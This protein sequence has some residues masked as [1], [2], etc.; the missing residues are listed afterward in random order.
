MGVPKGFEDLG[1][2]GYGNLALYRIDLSNIEKI[3]SL[4]THKAVV[5]SLWVMMILGIA[6]FLTAFS[7]S[8]IEEIP[9]PDFAGIDPGLFFQLVFLYGGLLY[10][11]LPAGLLWGRRRKYPK[12]L[13]IEK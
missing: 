4:I 11:I 5:G 2:Y 9:R 10:G 3:T 6:M 7:S 13:E 12:L 1:Q 8:F